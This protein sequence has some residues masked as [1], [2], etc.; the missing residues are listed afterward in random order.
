M[1][2]AFGTFAKTRFNGTTAADPKRKIVLFPC[3]PQLER[4]S[5]MVEK[6]TELGINTFAPLISDTCKVDPIAFFG[7]RTQ[8]QSL[9]VE[10]AKAAGRG[11]LPRVRPAADLKTYDF[12][13]FDLVLFVH[14]GET[15]Q[16]LK[17]A[18]QNCK[19]ENIALIVAP[20]EGFTPPELRVLEVKGAKAVT[21][22]TRTMQP[23]TAAIAATAMLFYELEG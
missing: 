7:L 20:E 4:F 14:Q 16:P 11:T 19:A 8:Y 3:L 9:A 21:L 12:S 22:G 2:R 18:L 13:E 10:T 6:C 15:A 17:A 5:C 1:I 23:D